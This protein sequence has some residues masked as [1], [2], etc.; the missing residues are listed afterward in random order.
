[1]A[2]TF[3]PYQSTSLSVTNSTASVVIPQN[4][5]TQKHVRIVNNGSVSAYIKFGLTGVTAA[6]T[7]MQILPGTVELFYVDTNPAADTVNENY[8]AAITASGTTTLNITA[9]E[10]D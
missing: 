10:I 3:K 8:I 1:M 5:D 9:G 4:V 2:L 6:T 7:D